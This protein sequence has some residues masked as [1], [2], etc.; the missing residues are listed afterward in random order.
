[1]IKP[2]A[3]I[4]ACLLVWAVALSANAAE[5]VATDADGN[6]IHLDTQGMTRKGYIVYIWQLKNLAHPDPN[7]ALSI[8]SQ[9]EFD[10]RFHQSRTMWITLHSERDEGGRVISSGMVPS[11]S[12]VPATEGSVDFTLLDYAC[13]RI[14]R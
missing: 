9:V 14:M 6:A 3:G 10:C 11:P 4:L 7:G 8:R 12:W 1:M 13:R 2:A 5:R